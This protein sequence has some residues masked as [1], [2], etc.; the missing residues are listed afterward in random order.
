MFDAVDKIF[1]SQGKIDL[2]FVKSYR[3][4]LYVRNTHTWIQLAENKWQ[5][6]GKP[7]VVELNEGIILPPYSTPQYGGGSHSGGVCDKNFRFYGGAL[8][9][10]DR[11]RKK[12]PGFLNLN[13]IYPVTETDLDYCD[14]EVIFGGFLVHSFGH[15]MIQSMARFW[16]LLKKSHHQIAFIQTQYTYWMDQWFELLDIPKER[17]LI[18]E[19]PT[20]FKK[21]IIPE[22]A[23]YFEEGYYGEFLDVI[24]HIRDKIVPN[25][26]FEKIYFTRSDL[27]KETARTYGEDYFEEFFEKKGYKIISP[28]HYSV[29]EKVGM[30]MGA[31]KIATTSGT[32]SHFSMFCNDGTEFVM[33]NR[34]DDF[35]EVPQ[36]LFNSFGNVKWTMID[37]SCDILPAHSSIDVH[38]IGPTKYWRKYVNDVYG[39][40][41]D[42]IEIEKRCFG[43][44]KEWCDFYMDPIHYHLRKNTPEYKNISFYEILRRLDLLIY[45]EELDKTVY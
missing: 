14:E 5:Y 44:L 2:S 19:R 13:E 41:V 31:Q 15:F 25:K 42:D 20:I 3:N 17:V 10:K 43:Y 11:F 39:E 24:K 37:V 28:E 8:R 32:S 7:N 12:N 40:E 23:I 30:I 6:K 21:V 36:A 38:W 34:K 22:E 16:Y 4:K 29:K 1:E 27:P 33:L 26:D 45:R 18:V 35:Q 9:F